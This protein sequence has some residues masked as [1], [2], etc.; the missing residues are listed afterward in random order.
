MFYFIFFNLKLGYWDYMGVDSKVFIPKS[1]PEEDRL[2]T[3]K[4]CI[5]EMIIRDNN[6]DHCNRDCFYHYVHQ[7]DDDIWKVDETFSM[8]AF[9]VKRIPKDKIIVLGKGDAYMLEAKAKAF[10][11]NYHHYKLTEGII[12][13][14]IVRR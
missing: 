6:R 9:Q 7:D 10:S 5:K 13:E 11:L 3:E 14:A 12:E 2:G 1:V 8:N 4:L